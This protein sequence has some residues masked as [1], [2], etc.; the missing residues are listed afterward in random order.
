MTTFDPNNDGID[1]L[2]IYI[3]AKTKLGQ[4]LS[5]FMYS[6]LILKEG[7]F[8]SIESYWYWL[9]TQDDSLRN[10]TGIAAKKKGRELKKQGKEVWDNLFKLKISAALFHKVIQDPELA[11][12]IKESLNLPLTHYYVFGGKVVSG[13]SEWVVEVWELIFKLVK[14][15]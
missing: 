6:P 9:Q 12:L 14:E 8:S 13:K 5:N 7:Y 1:H 2:N 10:L 11:I 15:N 3:K 4:K